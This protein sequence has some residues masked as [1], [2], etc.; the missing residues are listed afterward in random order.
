MTAVSYQCS[1]SLCCRKDT[2]SPTLVPTPRGQQ[3]GGVPALQQRAGR[4]GQLLP[5]LEA[6]SLLRRGADQQTE[7]GLLELPGRRLARLHLGNPRLLLQWWLQRRFDRQQVGCGFV[8]V[9]AVVNETDPIAALPF[10]IFWQ[11]E[12]KVRLLGTLQSEIFFYF[13]LSRCLGA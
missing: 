13:F 1:H 9:S 5:G 3:R 11:F 2:E 6:H 10:L 8:Q 12:A 7:R 4:E